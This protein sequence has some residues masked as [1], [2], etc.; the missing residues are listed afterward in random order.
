MFLANPVDEELTK[1]EAVMTPDLAEKLNEKLKSTTFLLHT[2]G[3]TNLSLPIQ[4][5]Y[6]SRK[7]IVMVERPVA[8]NPLLEISL[9]DYTPQLRE[10]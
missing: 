9:P 6:Q 7:Q 10:K 5:Y 3:L 1:A 4:P 2:A 8:G